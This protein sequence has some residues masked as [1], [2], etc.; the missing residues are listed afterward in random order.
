MFRRTGIVVAALMLV[1]GAAWAQRDQKP[2]IDV[3]KTSTC[4]CCKIWVE[5]LRSN[6]FT[7]KTTDVE[8]MSG[9]KAS[10]GVPA[11]LQ[12]CHT[13]VVDGY[14]LEGHVPAADIH[15]ILK[16]RPKV[17]GLAVPGMPIG[18]PGMEVKGV[19]PQPFDVMAF[20]K[21]G[22]STVYASHNR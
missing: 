17:A 7:V 22:K 19:T 13:G 10:R 12:S 2:T 5:H 21:G 15:R 3:F 6:G 1:S 4:G 9:I 18:S 16:E 11:K 8:D 20:E 14:V